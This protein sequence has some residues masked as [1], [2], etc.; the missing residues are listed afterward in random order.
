MIAPNQFSLPMTDYFKPQE[1]N[2]L[3]RRIEHLEAT[4]T[5]L[6]QRVTGHQLICHLNNNLRELCGLQP[7]HER[8]GFLQRTILKWLVLHV[9]PW[10]ER[11]PRSPAALQ[12]FIGTKPPS[13]FEADHAELVELLKTFESQSQEARLA[14]HPVF[15]PL[16]K[17]EWGEYMFLHLDYHLTA[18]GIHGDFRAPK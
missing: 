8:S 1:R 2:I 3:F 18:F 14:P 6:D 13:T 9:F 4:M 16:S 17:S 12:E 11:A 5:S 7:S 15:G 10:P